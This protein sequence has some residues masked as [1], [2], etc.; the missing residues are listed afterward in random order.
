MIVWSFTVEYD[1]VVH[2]CGCILYGW[3]VCNPN[4]SYS[5]VFIYLF[6]ITD[7]WGISFVSLFVRGGRAAGI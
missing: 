5:Y 2:L 6:F 3:I 4:G 7:G 1:F